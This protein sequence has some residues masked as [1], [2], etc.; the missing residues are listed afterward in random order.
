[1]GQDGNA[2]PG[3]ARNSWVWAA[4]GEPG[5]PPPG[6]WGTQRDGQRGNEKQM[7]WSLEWHYNVTENSGEEVKRPVIRSQLCGT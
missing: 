4:P 7:L 3:K 2:G 6:L 5:H 1:M